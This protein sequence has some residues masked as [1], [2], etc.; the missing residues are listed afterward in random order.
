M[1]NFNF[2]EYNKTRL[3]F[4]NFKTRLV[5]LGKLLKLNLVT[6]MS[7]QGDVRLGF[8][9]SFSGNLSNTEVAAKINEQCSNDLTKY[10]LVAPLWVLPQPSSVQS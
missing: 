7:G 2:K 4:Y 1:E 8:N 3:I 10:K 6:N 5:D 9:N